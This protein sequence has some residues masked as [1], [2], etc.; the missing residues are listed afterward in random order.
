[1]GHGFGIAVSCGVGCRCISDRALL[2]LWCRPAA[3]AL[4]RPLAW[5][6]PYATEVALKKIVLKLAD[7]AVAELA[8]GGADNTQVTHSRLKNLVP[9]PLEGKFWSRC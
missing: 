8:S 4:I 5:E 7:F 6:L 9:H 2:W 1:M 3:A